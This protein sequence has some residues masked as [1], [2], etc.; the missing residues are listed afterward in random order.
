MTLRERQAAVYTANLAAGR[1]CH[2]GV[3]DQLSKEERA[4]LRKLAASIKARS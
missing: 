2:W 4:E 1:Q 3:A